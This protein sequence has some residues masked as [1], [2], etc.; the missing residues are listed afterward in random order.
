MCNL[1]VL[2]HTTSRINY[3]R[4][5]RR[6]TFFL[7]TVKS[8]ATWKRQPLLLHKV[9]SHHKTQSWSSQFIDLLIIITSNF[10]LKLIQYKLIAIP[11]NVSS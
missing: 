9:K 3:E 10:S 6:Y 11:N 4:I 8:T 1:S 7:L 5:E 2:I